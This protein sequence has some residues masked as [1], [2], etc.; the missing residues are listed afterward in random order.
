MPYTHTV[1]ARVHQL[2]GTVQGPAPATDGVLSLA[3]C[4]T[5]QLHLL[6][7]PRYRECLFH[8]MP[9]VVIDDD[10][11]PHVMTLRLM[12]EVFRNICR[13]LVELPSSIRIAAGLAI[14]EKLEKL[15]HQEV[16]IRWA[17]PQY[18]S[19]LQYHA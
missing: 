5:R 19:A 1:Q 15:E 2:L 12:P 7:L 10:S 18:M 11:T 13:G 17:K 4:P 3:R 14:I 8:A 16:V 9:D 6:H